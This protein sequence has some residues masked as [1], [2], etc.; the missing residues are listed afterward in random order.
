M[1]WMQGCSRRYNNLAGIASM[2]L[3]VLV[4]VSVPVTMFVSV[5]VPTMPHEMYG[6]VEV[7]EGAHHAEGAIYFYS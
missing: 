2:V 6:M 5:F 7:C 1:V 4:R 3:C